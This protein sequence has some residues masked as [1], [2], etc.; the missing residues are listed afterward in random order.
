[1]LLFHAQVSTAASAAS[2]LPPLVKCVITAAMLLPVAPSLRTQDGYDKLSG[3]HHET[4]RWPI[5][6]S[7]GVGHGAQL[8]LLLCDISLHHGVDAA[9]AR[10]GDGI[11]GARAG[12][13][14]LGSSVQFSLF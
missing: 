3:E 13:G 1:M 4:T 8:K 11:I 12:A 6:P 2:A 14:D 5:D 10:D 9:R 7:R